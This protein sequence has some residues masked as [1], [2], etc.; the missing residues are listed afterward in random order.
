MADILNPDIV[1]AASARYFAHDSACDKGDELLRYV[2]RLVQLGRPD[3]AAELVQKSG[4]GRQAETFALER[5][6]GQSELLA[7]AF[8]SRGLVAARAVG[9]IVI[10]D[11][12]GATRGYGTGFMISP[13]LMMTNNHVLGSETTA[14]SSLIEF[15]Y[16]LGLDGKP[17]PPVRFRLDPGLFFVTSEPLDFTIT[18]VQPVNQEGDQVKDRGWIH[19]IA[20][21]GKAVVGEPIN[22]IQH[23]RGERQQI[24]FRGNTVERTDGDFLIY[25][26]DT[27][28]GSSGSPALNDQWQLAALHHAGVPDKDGMGNWLRKDGKI[29][30]RGLDDPDTVNWIAN[31]G[32]RIS[33]I[34]SYLNGL[35]LPGPRRDFF[36]EAFEPAPVMDLFRR[37]V[38]LGARESGAAGGAPPVPGNANV[39]ADGV[40]RWTFQLSF[41]P[42][43]GHA[44]SQAPAAVP[45]QPAMVVER[46]DDAADAGSGAS[47]AVESVFEPR[48]DYYDASKDQAAAAAYYAGLDDGLTKSKRYA[49]LRDLLQR[50]HAR[51]FGYSEARHKQLYPWIDRHED[52]SLKSVYSGDT[53]AEELFVAE[54]REFQAAVERATI[55]ESISSSSLEELIAR[56]EDALEA[57][58][59]FNCE[60]VVPQS[61]FAGAAETKAQKS[62]LHHLFTC[63]GGCNS[64]RSNI[65][66]A[67]FTPEEEAAIRAAEV[68][69]VEALLD[70]TKEAARPQC[71]LRDGRRFEPT[72]GKGAVARATLYF[73]LRYPGIVGDIKTGSKRELVKSNVGFL[74]DWAEAEPPSRYEKHRNAEIAKVQGNRNPLIDRPDWLRKIAFEDGFG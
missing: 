6:I 46:P 49:A 2:N 10:K 3:L 54:I 23:P 73:L 12:L 33:R 39:D 27:M 21:S 14:A 30:R 20:D 66:Y 15:D 48:G 1:E 69:P 25:A 68:T 57:S 32:V 41:G 26:T 19:L 13:R 22:I 36:E 31:E 67:D 47:T 51:V 40:A 38:E 53:M 43:P 45:A 71:G 7:V 42:V 58:G 17:M 60:H 64:F 37:D 62:D 4:E 70:P 50:T 56:E 8:F 11:S 52:Q 9:R 34:V 74:L 35:A 16:A 61:W 65:P 18:A 55:L 63:E 24:A 28:Q 72:A 44:P 59:P 29:Y 5:V